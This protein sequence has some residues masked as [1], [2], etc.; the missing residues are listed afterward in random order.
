[1]ERR[2]ARNMMGVGGLRTVDELNVISCQGLELIT[3]EKQNLCIFRSFGNTIHTLGGMKERIHY[4]S[5]IAT[6]KL[7]SGGL[8]ATI[9]SIFVRGNRFRPELP[10]YSN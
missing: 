4:F 10:Q 9:I 8:V 6:E 1:M 7:R 2:L 3:P 5:T